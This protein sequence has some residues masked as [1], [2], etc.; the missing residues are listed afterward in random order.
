MFVVFLFFWPP[1]VFTFSPICSCCCCYCNSTLFV[2]V[3]IDCFIMLYTVV[4]CLISPPHWL[5]VFVVVAA[6]ARRRSDDLCILRFPLID[7]CARGY[8][9]AQKLT[10]THTY[11][12]MCI[13]MGAATNDIHSCK[14][15]IYCCMH[16]L[17]LLLEMHGICCC[18]DWHCFLAAAACCLLLH[19]ICRC[20][21]AYFSQLV[22]FCL[23]LHSISW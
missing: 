5:L 19:R 11:V 1:T 4:A 10:H 9:A 12:Y 2:V 23:Y 17:T 22:Y 3:I 14:P 8:I 21:A 6:V 7:L 13:C 20:V 18:I 15:T 16:L